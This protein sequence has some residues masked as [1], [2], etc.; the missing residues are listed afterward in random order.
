MLCGQPTKSGKPCRLWAKACRFHLCPASPDAAAIVA[1][2]GTASPDAAAMVA[3]SGTA[4]PDAAAIVPPACA[5]APPREDLWDILQWYRRPS[6][7]WV[8]MNIAALETTRRKLITKSM[9]NV[10]CYDMGFLPGGGKMVGEDTKGNL[11]LPIKE[12]F[13]VLRAL[14]EEDDDRLRRITEEDNEDP[15]TGE[16]DNDG[17]S[18]TEKDN[19]GSSITEED[20]EELATGEEP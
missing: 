6:D 20:N 17:S 4:S 11:F 19:E 7:G 14:Q 15:A 9:I 1:A 18:I 8:C 12:A 5:A 3:A 16:E 10:C 13:R 2:S